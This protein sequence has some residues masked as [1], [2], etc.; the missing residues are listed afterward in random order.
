MKSSCKR[1]GG[2]FRLSLQLELSIVLS[3]LRKRE[4]V[5]SFAWVRN[6]TSWSFVTPF[7]LLDPNYLPLQDP[8]LFVL[9]SAAYQGCSWVSFL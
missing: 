8:F 1:E 7:L 5:L 4:W 6:E 9:V 2:C 3:P